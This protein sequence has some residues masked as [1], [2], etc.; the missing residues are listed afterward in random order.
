VAKIKNLTDEDLAAIRRVVRAE[1]QAVRNTTGRA[2][3]ESGERYLTP[4]TYV[5]KTPADGIPAFED[6]VPGHATCDIY[7]VIPKAIAKDLTA[8]PPEPENR[9]ELNLVKMENGPREVYSI[10]EQELAGNAW[11]IVTRD[12][13]GCFWPVNVGAD[14]GRFRA[15]LDGS[16]SK[17]HGCYNYGWHESVPKKKP[18]EF[19]EGPRFGTAGAWVRVTEDVKGDDT[20]AEVQTL[21]VE[22]ATD[23]T[24][25]TTFD[26]TIGGTTLTIQGDLSDLQSQ[27]E[28]LGF[29]TV[30]CGAGDPKCCTITWSDVGAQDLITC[31]ETKLCPKPKHPFSEIRNL[32]ITSAALSSSANPPR[33]YAWIR[34]QAKPK[35]TLTKTQTGVADAET[36]TYV[37]TKWLLCLKD[38]CSGTFT[39]TFEDPL[40]PTAAIQFD[41]TASEIQDALNAVNGIGWVVTEDSDDSECFALEITEEYGDFELTLDS[42]ELVDCTNYDFNWFAGAGGD[43]DGLT[44]PCCTV[45]LACASKDVVVGGT[46][47]CVGGVP[48]F[49]PTIETIH[50]LA[51]GGESADSDVV[52]KYKTCPGETCP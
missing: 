17:R 15:L 13:D 2:G 49:N 44:G 25:G 45:T 5:A 31:D 34:Y 19:E 24:A 39:L 1:S 52:I 7:R 20:T 30:V 22:G 32:S 6:P 33:V 8:D 18:C 42:T 11:M 3:P 23:C 29:A 36:N 37:T 16:K 4:E 46:I 50:Y 9:I 35:A 38:Y 47:T 41:A 10:S 26:A 14:R 51:C 21:C 12:K 48:T 40:P 43:G 27:V 28:A